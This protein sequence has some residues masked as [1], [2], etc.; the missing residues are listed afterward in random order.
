MRDHCSLWWWHSNQSTF[1]NKFFLLSHATYNTH[2]VSHS[3]WAKNQQNKRKTNNNTHT[4]IPNEKIRATWR[5]TISKV[6]RSAT[7]KERNIEILKIHIIDQTKV[8]TPMG[9]VIVRTHASKRV[10]THAHRHVGNLSYRPLN[11]IIAYT[12]LWHENM[13][14]GVLWNEWLDGNVLLY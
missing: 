12:C 10:R 9:W 14:L 2:N 1:Q 6:K 3:N 7:P 13:I 8:K 5:K 11:R 4:H